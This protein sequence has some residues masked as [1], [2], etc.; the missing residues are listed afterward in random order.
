MDHPLQIKCT[1]MILKLL[2]WQLR[3]ANTCYQCQPMLPHLWAQEAPWCLLYFSPSAY[4]M[5]C[6]L[7]TKCPRFHPKLVTW[8]TQNTNRCKLLQPKC[9]I[10]NLRPAKMAE[11]VKSMNP[12]GVSQSSETR[13]ENSMAVGKSSVEDSGLSGEADS[14]ETLFV[15]PIRTIHSCVRNQ[16]GPVPISLENHRIGRMSELLQL[17]TR[18]MSNR[19]A[20]LNL[21]ITRSA[22]TQTASIFDGI[23]IPF[24]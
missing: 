14:D 17:K 5:D 20:A 22:L 19:L 12:T 16:S 13:I 9:H 7:S 21:C 18:S 10:C 6:H 4:Q 24:E 2:I 15:E 3:K 11:E 23:H 8:R 1:H